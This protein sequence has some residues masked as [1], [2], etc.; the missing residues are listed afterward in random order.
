MNARC[1]YANGPSGGAVLYRLAKDE[2]DVKFGDMVS[3]EGRIV[4]L[5]DFLT[6]T[7]NKDVVGQIFIYLLQQLL[8]VS[9]NRKATISGDYC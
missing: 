4:G 2:D 7:K 3:T 8:V 5:L 1:V 9:D 6:A